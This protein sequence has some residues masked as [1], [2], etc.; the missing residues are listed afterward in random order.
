MQP[1][2]TQHVD[3]VISLA[4][5]LNAHDLDRARSFL[6]DDMEFVGVFGPLLK[7]AEAYLSAM[8]SLRA[9]Q[10]ILK[11][12]A[13]E[14]DV[15]CFYELTLPSAPNNAIFG[16]GWFKITDGRVHFIRVVF[17]PTSLSKRM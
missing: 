12:F 7:G 17:D 4:D 2:N 6:A 1:T 9:N 15:G 3:L 11:I 14:T 5:A 8:G 13:D 10:R 16:C